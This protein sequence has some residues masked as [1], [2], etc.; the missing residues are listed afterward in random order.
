MRGH[1]YRRGVDVEMSSAEWRTLFSSVAYIRRIGSGVFA[2][3][4]ENGRARLVF[5]VYDNDGVVNLR[6]LGVRK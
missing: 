4:R 6:H 3:E 2:Y 1:D 5:E